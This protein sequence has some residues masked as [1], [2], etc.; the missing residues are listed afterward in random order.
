MKHILQSWLTVLSVLLLASG[1]DA[2]SEQIAEQNEGR[3]DFDVLDSRDA[4]EHTITDGLLL[5][6]RRAGSVGWDVE[7]LPNPPTPDSLNL[8]YHSKEWHGPYPCQVYAWSFAEKYFP[9]DRKF[10]VRGFPCEVRIR[11]IDCH[12]EGTGPGT[13]FTA[14]RIEVLWRTIDD[15][16]NNT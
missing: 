14:G 11:L 12:T 7:V 2:P 8:L 13:R 1:C 16:P 4:I 9:N 10:T 6:I 15:S 3:I 5:R